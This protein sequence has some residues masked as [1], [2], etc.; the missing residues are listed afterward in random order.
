M[1]RRRDQKPRSTVKRKTNDEFSR[2]PGERPPPSPRSGY[3]HGDRYLDKF[4]GVPGER[5]PPAPPLPAVF[6]SS[7]LAF[8]LLGTLSLPRLFD[9][10]LFA[11]VFT[12]AFCGS[13]VLVGFPDSPFG[14]PRNV[15]GGHVISALVG[16]TV[17]E[18]VGLIG[19]SGHATTF[20]T[21]PASVAIAITVM[22]LTRTMHPPAAGT[23]MTAAGLGFS[24][25]SFVFARECQPSPLIY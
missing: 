8:I 16:L 21:A 14:Q 18:A 15:V 10:R 4:S 25:A 1:G 17:G 3:L 20:V 22:L 9:Q 5:P 6:M 23:A 12:P 19:V 2:V 7:I 11:A 13:A 24:G